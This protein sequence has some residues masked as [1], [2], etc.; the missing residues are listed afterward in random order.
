MNKDGF[1]WVQ[2]FDDAGWRVGELENGKWW[3]IG[4][5]D[6]WTEDELK[7]IGPQIFPPE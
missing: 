5:G 6:S 4:N 2:V 7:T 3:I 1:Y